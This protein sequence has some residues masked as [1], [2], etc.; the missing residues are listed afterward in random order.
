MDSSNYVQTQLQQQGTVNQNHM[1]MNE[2]E[3]LSIL[4]NSIWDSVHVD[5]NYF[6][7]NG[8]PDINIFISLFHQPC[9]LNSLRS[10]AKKNS[11]LSK[12]ATSVLKEWFINNLV[13][14]YP[15]Q[16]EKEELASQSGLTVAQVS[17]WFINSRRRNLDRLRKQYNVVVSDKK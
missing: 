15:T 17:N 9:D 12:D 8:Q 5:K 7:S 6:E 4:C 2:S 10:K 11:N 16:S 1:K 13:K 14:P 3:L